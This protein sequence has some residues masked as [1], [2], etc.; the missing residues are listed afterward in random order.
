M[1]SLPS[2]VREN[3]Y[4]N[5]RDHRCPHDA[6]L[7]A[8]EVYE[9]AEG[10][11]REARRSSIKITLLGAY[12]DGHIILRY[13][14]VSNYSL[15]GSRCERGHGDWLADKLEQGVDGRLIHE[16][17]WR[18]LEIGTESRWRIEAEDVTYEWI[19]QAA[20][21]SSEIKAPAGH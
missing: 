15:A 4:L 19:P 18:G 7:E 20:T 14:G 16:I 6:W 11:R 9:P 8:V 17:I 13:V 2:F 1:A 21:P 12:H 5:P 3:W 10:A